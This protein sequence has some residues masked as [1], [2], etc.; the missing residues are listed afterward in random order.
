MRAARAHYSRRAGSIF[1]TPDEVSREADR[2]LSCRLQRAEPEWY[3]GTRCRERD[4]RGALM[5]VKVKDEL[6]GRDLALS[7]FGSV[8]ART[9]R[10]CAPLCTED[11]VVQSMP[12]CSPAK[13]HLA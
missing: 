10:L 1:T 6:A 2:A 3:I 8:R 4:S 5:K 12:D 11:Y 7:R 9:E 13:W